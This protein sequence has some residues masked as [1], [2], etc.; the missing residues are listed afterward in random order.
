[1]DL[2]STI[3]ADNVT[4]ALSRPQT[5]FDS[6]HN[7][8]VEGTDANTAWTMT[9]PS[10][11]LWGD[12]FDDD[13][14]DR[15]TW[16]YGCATRISVATGLWSD[17]LNW[18]PPSAPVS[19]S[20]VLIAANHIVTVD[21]D[22]ATSSTMTIAG[23]LYFARMQFS[24]M[25]IV[26]GSITVTQS[27]HLD[28]GTEAD[29][30]GYGA[31]VH[32]VLAYGTGSERYGLTV[33]DGG[34][35]T[36]RGAT[37]SPIGF[38]LAS[39]AG[40]ASSFDIASTSATGWNLG[41]I[42][43]LGPTTGNGQSTVWLTTIT[44]ISGGARRT[45]TFAPATGGGDTR[46][47]S[48]TT[49]ILIA[50][51]TRNVLV[52]SS[53]TDTSASGDTAYISNLAQNATSFSLV[54]G[55][56]AH[57]GANTASKFAVTFEGA[58]TRG[59]I[60]SSTVRDGYHGIHFNASSGN[61]LDFNTV[62]AN[63]SR[64]IYLE[65]SSNNTLIGNNVSASAGFAILLNS[66]SDNNTLTANNSYSNSNHSLFFIASDNNTATNNNFYSN[67]AM[68]IN[69]ASGSGNNT[70][71][72]NNSY[73]NSSIGI[74]I[75][76]AS[77]NNTLT[78]NNSWL[79]SMGVSLFSN[80]NNNLLAANN[81]YSN[82]SFGM[83]F[84][85]SSNNIVTS[86][87]SYSNASDGLRIDNATNNTI[88]DSRFGFDDTGA[89]LPNT[90]SEVSFAGGG[91]LKTLI[92]KGIRI[93][94]LGVGVTGIDQDGA[95]LLSYDQDFTT[96]SLRIYGDYE[97]AGS[98]LTI[99]HNTRIYTS[100]HT[101]PKTM[102]ISAGSLH[103]VEV[104]S[105]DDASAV[106]QL[107]TIERQGGVWNV[108][109]SGSGSLGVLAV[110]G[111]AGTDF[112]QF[113]LGITEGSTPT[114]GDKL[115][116]ALLGASPIDVIQKQLLFE[117]AAAGFNDG[118]SRLRVNANAGIQL[119]GI[120]GAHVLISTLTTNSTWYHFVSSGGFN[121]TFTS[122]TNMT[123]TGIELALGPNS[124]SLSSS[125]F[126]YLG[127]N[128]ATNTYITLRD[129]DS[130]I[131]ADNVTFA[132]S[133]SSDGFDSA[134]NIR[135]EGADA[136]TAWSMTTPN[137]FLW[138]ETHDDDP[139]ARVTWFGPAP[140]NP[141]ITAV[142]QGT[143]TVTWGF[144]QGD[145]GYLLEA[146]TASDFSGTLESS[147]TPNNFL[148]TLTVASLDFNTTYFLRA[149]AVYGDTTN[150]APTTPISTATLTEVPLVGAPT[151]T[152]VH[153]SSI[154]AQWSVGLNPT[155][156]L[157]EVQASSTNFAAGTEIRS[158]TT[159]N[160]NDIVSNLQ[161]NTTYFLRVRAINWNGIPSSFLTL[162]STSTLAPA[163][164]NPTITAVVYTTMT[165]TW[166]DVNATGYRVEAS[167]TNFN[168]T[169][170]LRSTA[171]PNGD[172]TTLVL[173]TLDPNTTYFVRVGAL[174][175]N[176]VPTYA[177]D[178]GS[179][180][181]A[182]PPLSVE[183][184]RVNSTSVT[185]TWLPLPASP[186]NVTAEGYR[187]EAATAA[188]FTG[189]LLRSSS[190]FAGVQPSTLTLTNMR[191]GT[192][193]YFRIGSLNWTET[194]HYLTFLTT[195]TKTPPPIAPTIDA[196]HQ[197]SITVSWGGVDPLNGY[198]LEASTASDFSGTI[199][200]SAT[201][202]TDL[203]T[204]TVESLFFNTTYYVR[205]GSIWGA[206]T[207]YADAAPAS[208]A[209]LADIPQLSAPPF[210]EV[211]FSSISARWAPASNPA[212][213]TL[214]EMQASSTNFDGSGVLHSS[215]TLNVSALVLALLTN[216][217]Y[218]FRVRAVNHNEIPTDY[219]A[220]G[221][222]STLA[223]PPVNPTITA[224]NHTTM[225]VSWGDVNT[226]AYRVEASS[227]NFDGTGTLYSSATTNGDLTS[228]VV[229]SLEPNTTHYVRV[230]SYNHNSVPSYAVDGGS[231]TL[232][233]PVSGGDAYQTYTTSLTVNWLPLPSAPQ[234]A[235]A[236]GYRLE[237]STMTDFTGTVFS[238]I[239]LGGIEPSTFTLIGLR[240]NTTYYLRA[241]SLNW[242]QT[243]HFVSLGSTLTT[244]PVPET[245]V[246][247]AVFGTSVTVSWGP[248]DAAGGYL[249]EASTSANFTGTIE[250]SATPLGSLASLTVESL[251]YNTT[252]FLRIGAIWPGT[253]AYAPIVFTTATFVNDPA[254]GPTPFSAIGALVL[255]GAWSANSNPGGTLFETVV[256]TKTPLTL[257][258]TGNVA[259]ST[260]P[261]GSPS[262]VYSAL[263]ANTT[264]YLFGRA[265]GHNGAASSY[266]SLGA[267][268]TLALPPSNVDITAVWNT[269]MTVSWNTVSAVSY[270]LEASST[271]FGAGIVRSSA[272][273]NAL[274]TTLTVQTLLANTTY[275]V[276]VG[277]VNHNG[278]STFGIGNA[279]STLSN[280]VSGA[281][282]ATVFPTSATISWLPLPAAP[283][284]ASAEGYHVEASTTP[285][286]TGVIL[287]SI[288]KPGIEP[289]TLTVQAL[290]G[291]ATYYF[292]VG[293]LNWEGKLNYAFAGSTFTN[294]PPPASPVITDV[295]HGSMTVTWGAVGSDEG[296]I[297]HA[298]TAS[299]FSG[300]LLSSS[301]LSPNTAGLSIPGMQ[302]NT[303]YYLRA[304]AIWN[305]ATVYALTTPK[306]TATLAAETG[307]SAP[308]ITAVYFSSIAA[309]WTNG[310]NP[311]D[312]RYLLEASSTNYDGSGTIFS[313][314]T[315]N[316][317]DQTTSLAFNTTYYL[318]VKAVNH[319]DVP[320]LYQI[321]GATST[322]ADRPAGI[323]IDTVYNSSMSVRWSTV[324]AV[325][326][327]VQ[328]SS[329]GF[330]GTGQ[331]YSSSTVNGELGSLVVQSLL[332]NTT[333]LVRVSAINHNNTP[334][335]GL[336][337]SSATLANA[338]SNAELF[339][340][341]AT[342]VTTQWTPLAA[343]PQ[344]ATAE[345][346]RLDFS[347]A[348]DF[349]G[350]VF[351]S[352]TANIGLSTLTVS[353]LDA[354]TT[355]YLRAA[356]LNWADEPHYVLLGSTLTRSPKPINP[357][358][359]IVELSSI[360]V[361]WGDIEPDEGYILEAS[362]ASDFSGVLFSSITPTQSTSSLIVDTLAFNTTYFLRV[363]A[364][365]SGTTFYN[366]TSPV[367]TATL[368]QEAAPN[369]TPFFDVFVASIGAQWLPNA[370]PAETQFLIEASTAPDFS[371]TITSSNV[372]ASSGALSSLLA[373]T[374]Y[375][376]RV[377]AIN[378][379]GVPS[380][381]LV[382]GSTSTLAQPPADLSIDEVFN[383][384]MTIR[385]STVSSRGYRVEASSTGFDGTGLLYSSSTTNGESGTLVLSGLLANTTVTVRVGSLNNNQVPNNAVAGSSATLTNPVTAT[386][387]A[388]VFI[389]SVAVN[390]LPLPAA[391]Q[392]QSAQ[393]YR[394]DASTAAD[395][396]G[397]LFSSTTLGVLPSTL[398]VTG[399]SS[400][401]TYYF[402]AGGLNWSSLPHYRVVGS[403]LTSSV[404]PGNP[405]VT[406]VWP[407]SA[408][409]SWVAVASNGGYKVD[410]ST[411]PDFSGTL[412]TSSTA[413]GADTTVMV[414]GLDFNTTYY[415]RVG[416]VWSGIPNYANTTPSSTPTL[417]NIPGAVVP[418]FAEVV[419]S[420]ISSRWTN[421]FNPPGTTYRL[422]ASSTN[423]QPGTQNVVID[424]TL[425]ERHS[426]GL[427][428][429]TTYSMRVAGVNHGGIV[430]E[431][432]VIGD[433]AT[434]A[435]PPLGPHIEEAFHSSMTVVW[436]TVPSNGYTLILSS[437]NFDGTGILHSSS[438][439]NTQLGTL[440]ISGLLANT[441]YFAQV[442]SLNHNSAAHY[443]IAG[444]SSTLANQ[445]AGPEF[446]GVFPTSATL[447]WN[448]LP[449]APQ[450][451]SAEGYFIEASSVADFTGTLLS[452]TTLGV[453]QST[454]TV[455]A[456]SPGDT[457]YFR[458]ASL[459][460][461]GRRHYVLA[462]STV[463]QSPAPKNPLVTAVSG[464]SIVVTWGNVS[465]DG[466]Y[467]LQA[468]TA[469]NFT[470][471]L[472]SSSTLFTQVTGLT[473]EGLNFNTTYYLQ[474]GALWAGSTSYANTTPLSTSTLVTFVT[475][476]VPPFVNVE[477]SSI[478]AQWAFGANPVGTRY[479]LEASST[480]FNGSG[481]IQ[482]SM[483][484]ATTAYAESLLPN[485]TYTFRTK[486]INHNGIEGPFLI[487]GATSTLAPIP[488]G[489]APIAVYPS[490][491][492]VAWT[493]VLSQGYILEA[494]STN[495]LGGT[496]VLSSRTP[497]SA[498]TALSVSGLDSN[499]TYYFRVG[500]LNHNSTPH[501]GVGPGT[502]TLTIDIEN[503]I[504]GLPTF[505]SVTASW[506]PFVLAP[507]SMSA[508]AFRLEVST[509]AD[510]SGTVVSS[511]T[512]NIQES[513][514]TVNGLELG[515]LFYLRVAAEN[516]SGHPN[517]ALLGSTRTVINAPTD[518][519]LSVINPSSVTITWGDVSPDDGYVIDASTAANF[520]GTVFSSRSIVN[521]ST[522]TVSGL[523]PD[524]TY[525]FRAGSVIFGTTNYAL[526][527]PTAALT[528]PSDPLPILPAFL[529]ISSSTV[530]AQWGPGLPPNPDATGYRLEASSSNFLGGTITFSSMVNTTSGTTT[531][532]LQNTTYTLRVRAI[533]QA[534]AESSILV[535]GSTSTLAAKVAGLHLPEVFLTSITARWDI[536]GA[537]GYNVQASS[538]NFDGT[539]VVIS[540]IGIGAS[541]T[542]L[543]VSGLDPNTTYFVR[544]GALNHN[545]VLNFTAGASSASL[546][547]EVQN[548]QIV[549]VFFSSVTLNWSPLPANPQSA[550]ALGY[551]L[552]ASTAP[553]FSGTILSIE[554]SD[555]FVSTLTVF[556]L[557]TFSTYYLRV[558]AINVG[559]QANFVLVGSTLTFLPDI[560]VEE[561]G[562]FADI[563]QNVLTWK[564]FDPTIKTVDFIGYY[565][566]RTTDILI[567]ATLIG[568]TTNTVFIDTS[569]VAGTTYFYQGGAELAL[570]FAIKRTS[571]TAIQARTGIPM[572]PFGIWLDVQGSSSTLSWMRVRH[573]LS[574]VP[575]ND[576]NNPIFD[577]L[578]SYSIY[579]STSEIQA[580]WMNIGTVP[581]GTHSFTDPAGGPQFFYH[582]KAHNITEKS[583]AS[584]VQAVISSNAF[585]VDPDDTT[586]LEIPL[587]LKIMLNGDGNDPDTAYR[588]GVSS[589]PE[590]I[591]GR[592]LKAIKFTPYQGGITEI[593]SFELPGMATLRI[594]Y[595]E[596]AGVVVPSGSQVAGFAPA[597]P[598]TTNPTP[599][600]TAVYWFDGAK[601]V[602]LY[603]ILDSQKKV[604]IFQT[605]YLGAYQI[606]SVERVGGFNFDKGGVSNRF[607]TPNNDTLNDTAIFTFDNP[608]DSAVTGKILDLKGAHVSNMTPG[609]IL[610]SLEW[611]AKSN[612]QVVPGGVYIYQIGA[613]DILFN[614]TV[615]VIK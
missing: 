372:F 561:F 299:D 302:L 327:R 26:G 501:Y 470:G 396:T 307:V 406:A 160:T 172:L 460:W 570:G 542:Q 251:I 309:Q 222:T 196:V 589:H 130:T 498:A 476:Q 482:S 488:T 155:P 54:Y 257:S 526:T 348:P 329:T 374:T 400:G 162:A 132:L 63:A 494:S 500:S 101:D 458:I 571:F 339:I 338:V 182:D 64:G 40:G 48:D 355:Y 609:P 333:Y 96:G 246:L 259:V 489:I 288:S 404:K 497:V 554:N 90:N 76:N 136:N 462:G 287:S 281:E 610:N 378:H 471:T 351:S 370:N 614:G 581:A 174:N 45:V 392:D 612:G 110:A 607:I 206:A 191:G 102:Q 485:T 544:A 519:R 453:L 508:T 499:T 398:T 431:Y 190:T 412:V 447:T 209:T 534:G 235:T 36:V 272:T 321:L 509:V 364:Q 128:G 201:S 84:D 157:F 17:D 390:W 615:I 562:G 56:F 608:R 220:I 328:A 358:I 233:D 388:G 345:G 438:T 325:G 61:T 605:P 89:N 62:Y 80:A 582:V 33:D 86:N 193:Y 536:S 380:L 284:D 268:S 379:S 564:D 203:L 450:D 271:N 401:V 214:Y 213:T 516:I 381:S 120:D 305:G 506:K 27:G 491:V 347:T 219:F 433:T 435:L 439:P 540:S 539:G 529:G 502:H 452:S 52:R 49:P 4:F 592:V 241:G 459:N 258:H 389:T 50:N 306:S 204:L 118:R 552:E 285:D 602:Q 139:N 368:A 30:L 567:T 31:T 188:N 376:L 238:S 409:V 311:G 113:R 149:G 384:S 279:S 520:S 109:G 224:V 6:A 282:F 269:S 340:V 579:R 194:P 253:T 298:S 474:A 68:G 446:A 156:T 57:I 221:S 391:P 85:N 441:T 3:T 53:G 555:V 428:P 95:Y 236:E 150:Y 395:F 611:D 216:T 308:P 100:T 335:T 576:I 343:A 599:D 337:T 177:I 227:T 301:S 524:T 140:V 13:P 416:A 125:T 32:L 399:L 264:Y 171:T 537:S 568:A 137:G 479:R 402:R 163:P 465:P 367:S 414:T 135:V 175:H 35:F 466:G 247:T 255:T 185:L 14:N 290:I 266:V 583:G 415:V 67:S 353:G 563:R 541:H 559:H 294:A 248:V 225:T 167:S 183:F 9:S 165:V 143:I 65:V 464:T 141:T 553:D 397:A 437:T 119:T 558:G 468:S 46:T 108:T 34:D 250:S 159:L 161:L 481:V 318:R 7:I 300:T 88:I 81:F 15:V 363:G 426:A 75:N 228:M 324:A 189:T 514:L 385:W 277:A 205:A 99:D 574:Q 244:A 276:R 510:F 93:N 123:H 455:T 310:S 369:P 283:S 69:L 477:L 292:R 82:S 19:C 440:S 569:V 432:I 218:S 232:S 484:K 312:T 420:S 112:T 493:P 530:E 454:L 467:L 8:R 346:Y 361:T 525:Y 153:F 417:T 24:S 590:E 533:G 199:K 202:V 66:S 275:F 105:T 496:V 518:P 601:W 169:G 503:A 186:Q 78:G 394:V 588:I 323:T 129:F 212:S 473:V 528:R 170:T 604:L 55:E 322:R 47:L 280:L 138:G 303:T 366:L 265:F 115:D 598:V 207:F 495:F 557:T 291:Q 270:R 585:I 487:L 192:T 91:G 356:S 151:F 551:R 393:G 304:G 373:N 326:Y 41:D 60:S 195:F 147:S 44:A 114:D 274:L 173:D 545:G 116:F 176:N 427:L 566:Y 260:R 148:T 79:N 106:S 597:A 42:I 517:Y 229:D 515:V 168:G 480:A 386:D 223:D 330:N 565:V 332:A 606:R 231:T 126:D 572:A 507:G 245:P 411:S 122:F 198:V 595:E 448:A 94:S 200:S 505:F 600:Q 28:M 456:L 535:L 87:H 575:F 418:A 405:L 295:H 504:I 104:C 181:L 349:S 492:T 577:E 319:N 486:G 158:S 29:V 469:S 560:Q 51:L 457:W 107:I 286:F 11:V 164:I 425:F 408:T 97:V 217:T 146:S 547:V 603:G 422:E 252:Y 461:D 354:D 5:G 419:V 483:T 336:G 23:T 434:L 74:Y 365:W 521:L 511:R 584:M 131:T 444:G 342:S 20:A 550:T 263:A 315:L 239:S 591:G 407:S 72:A 371:G 21:T 375:T 144:V 413:G 527:T 512:S 293:T 573:F 111:C 549:G 152:D 377:A 403:T 71:G 580:P 210:A 445:V 410:A 18:S 513:T 296:Y 16:D 237:A 243:P 262:A 331:I 543:I 538:T 320:S 594:A 341:G 25:T 443:R 39:I 187:V 297:L 463:T 37:K 178:G 234:N 145:S 596:L 430:G 478:S 133:R 472:F 548:T 12:A 556:N 352:G 242:T 357:T 127:F 578:L 58:G 360:T 1:R 184:F 197:S 546:A 334:T 424:T 359:T 442:G 429:N 208:T 531:G 73:S 350:S 98:T 451:L 22:T 38:A 289:S 70:L 103:V 532:L 230:V 2:D 134:H 421:N 249:L 121:V 423:F 77:S 226:V 124:V 180:T 278:I 215:N 317:A 523:T 436:S 490:S 166:E 92:L 240:A 261:E 314:W 273:N 211:F 59:S 254:A 382:I 313:S 83:N 593:D 154:A 449:V 387:F 117:T 522:L 613:E 586:T 383:T 43:T 362:T 475:A 256:T 10:G 587:S 267:T 344:E 142:Y 179:T 316:T